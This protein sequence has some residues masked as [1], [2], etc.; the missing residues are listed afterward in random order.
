MKENNAY[1]VDPILACKWIKSDQSDHEESLFKYLKMMAD[2]KTLIR[3]DERAMQ[4]LTEI[5][6]NSNKTEYIEHTMDLSEKYGFP[7]F[8]INF[9]TE[10]VD[11]LTGQLEKSPASLFDKKTLI[12]AEICVAIV[13]SFSNTC[14]RFCTEF[15]NQEGIKL[16]LSY[17]KNETL[18]EAY[19]RLNESKENPDIYMYLER[20]L[21][22][23][24]GCLVNLAKV[25][26]VTKYNWF[27]SEG[28]LMKVLQGL[29]VR[30]EKVKD[31]QLAIF[32][33]K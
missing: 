21:R 33:G 14:I 17:L 16:L 23:S 5:Y 32:I 11:F 3:D 26:S 9:M 31:C 6:M 20:I 13:R 25:Y 18:L 12:T 4:A 10:E 1:S 2:N 7:T 27:K 30:L 15:V 8:L 29:S 28:Q 22:G 24:I 19:L